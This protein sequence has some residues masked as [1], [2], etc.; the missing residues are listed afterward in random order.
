MEVTKRLVVYLDGNICLGSCRSAVAKLR[1]FGGNIDIPDLTCLNDEKFLQITWTTPA[2]LS[3]RTIIYEPEV[4]LKI[5][6]FLLL[7]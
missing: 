5:G 2:H 3:L 7:N 1:T 4:L 6:I